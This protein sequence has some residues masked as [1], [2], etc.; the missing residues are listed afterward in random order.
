MVSMN[1]LKEDLTGNDKVCILDL[2][3]LKIK[4]T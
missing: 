3:K 4:S 2:N 1:M